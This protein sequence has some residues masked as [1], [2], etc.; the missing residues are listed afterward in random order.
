M[1]DEGFVEMFANTAY[2][3]QP[4]AAARARLAIADR[5]REPMASSS[6]HGVQRAPSSCACGG[7]CPR[8][9]PRAMEEAP[10]LDADT[11]IAATARGGTPLPDGLRA[12]FE[13]RFGQD[14]ANVRIHQDAAAAR[15]V[16][17]RAYTAGSHIVFDTGEYAPGTPE[18]KRLLAHELTHVVQQRADSRPVV[19]R[20]ALSD[21]EV[22]NKH[23]PIYGWENIRNIPRERLRAAG[24]VFC[25]P[26]QD[27]G[28]P[29]LWERWVHP[30]KGV[31]HYQVRWQ[32]EPKPPE[33][34]DRQ[35]R[36]ADPCMEASDDEDSCNA[37]CL[38]KIPESDSAC[39]RTCAAACSNKLSANT[40]DEALQLKSRVS[41]P[42]DALELEANA[43]ADRVLRMADP[44]LNA[45]HIGPSPSS[46]PVIHREPQPQADAD[47]APAAND[48]M[49][50]Y[51]FGPLGAGRMV[52]NT[53]TTFFPPKAPQD[54]KG[55][56]L[57]AAG[58]QAR[59]IRSR[60][61]RYFTI[62]TKHRA[63]PRQPVPPFQV[64]AVTEW[65]PDDGSSVVKNAEEDPLPSY[66]GPGEPLGTKL[67]TEYIFANDRP[68]TLTI[69]YL[70][71]PPEG[72][73]LLMAHSVHY[74]D[75]TTP[76]ATVLSSEAK[77][78]VNQAGAVSV[79]A[80]TKDNP[81]TQPR[82]TAD[83]PNTTSATQQTNPKAEVVGQIT[84]LTEAIKRTGDAVLRDP[85]VK[86]L[87]DWLAKVQPFL[88]AKDAQQMID[89]A[90]RA[91]I[92]D[93]V[94]AGIM[95]ILKAVTGI[96]PQT[97]PENRNQTGPGTP[98]KDLG[99]HIVQGPKITINDAPKP[100]PR[101]NFEYKG[102]PLAS[103]TAGAPMKFT[104]VPP[105]NFYALNGG[106]RL[107]VTLAADRNVPNP[108]QRFATVELTSSSPKVID[109]T[110]PD[111]PGKYVVRVDV[112]MGPD[113][114][115][116][117]EF[118]VTAGTAQ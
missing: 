97:M 112:G 113:Y 114:S 46:G 118:E 38:E 90:V 54:D 49:R 16:Q 48:M 72:T 92:K 26:D 23:K 87:R 84:Q 34:D 6:W 20:E 15:A 66:Y 82:P 17:A 32:E 33:P 100:M 74:M 101:L 24:F 21:Q 55:N 28:D 52:M 19:H 62:D 75:G 81:D 42:G 65:R 85:L 9:Q 105:D 47:P 95:A 58:S 93:G 60:W 57:V 27:F 7:A 70:L 12:W 36:C 115:S 73:F 44:P 91:L 117:R 11:A 40:P 99:E 22:C 76:G 53:G 41:M 116:V 109:I 83:Q 111:K 104:I 1:S 18:G 108:E 94:D 96:S 37:C 63:Y 98:T 68:G 30:T 13:P 45:P 88:P 64:K 89:D 102:G 3:A 56:D 61:G 51:S 35:K 59:P 77:P 31:L 107:V 14:F 71:T 103:Y 50:I 10:G 2:M 39:R 80:P 4:H 8:C 86:G 69:G 78:D 29:K 79:P 110:A 25:G 67:G 106:K 43:M 5:Q